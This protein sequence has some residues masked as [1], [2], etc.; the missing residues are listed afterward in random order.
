LLEHLIELHKRKLHLRL[1]YSALFYYLRDELRYSK[2]SASR[3]IRGAEVL[4]RYPEVGPLLRQGKLSLVSLCRL[5]PILTDANHKEVLERASGHTEE[6]VELLCAKLAPQ[7]RTRDS[8]REVSPTVTVK[9][10]NAQFGSMMEPLA[11]PLACSAEVP[12]EQSCRAKPLSEKLVSIHLTVTRAFMNELNEVK[13]LL[14]HKVPSGRLEEVLLECIRTT[15]KV[16]KQR[17]H[18]V[19]KPRKE[20]LTCTDGSYVPAA[21]ARAVRKKDGNC[22][23]FVGTNGKRCGSKRCLQ[24]DHIIP[25]AKDGKTE[26]ANLRLLCHAH[27]QLQADLHFGEG[28]MQQFRAPQTPSSRQS[29]P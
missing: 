19:E 3:R 8:V 27:H 11:R 21:L 13:D 23:A 26:L 12:R 6:E 18:E 15:R 9:A 10:P 16:R 29:G 17:Q 4:V 22:C 25:R 14:G 2:G 1:G 28:F 5:R 7:A 24:I 20:E